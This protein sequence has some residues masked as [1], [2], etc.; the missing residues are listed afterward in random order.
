MQDSPDRRDDFDEDDE[1]VSKTALKK[2]A[3]AQQE[4]GEALTELKDDLLARIP[5]DD[6]LHSAI[7]ETRNI[8]KNGA[9]KRHMQYIGK[10][11]RSADHEAI[12]AAYQEI[13]DEQQ[14]DARRLHIVEGWRDRLIDVNESAAL[15]DF[16][17]SFPLA[18]RQQIRQ[19]SKNAQT[20]QAN[21]KPPT[22]ARKLFKLL[23]ETLRQA[24]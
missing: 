2:E 7:I 14:S 10:L 19:V 21:N 20:D 23:R 18:D 11:M 12:Q 9:K 24:D 1:I 17:D 4:L 5:L 22:N 13:E 16:F 3:L 6:T 15:A 8:K